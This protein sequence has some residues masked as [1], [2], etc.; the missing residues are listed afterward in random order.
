[1]KDVDVSVNNAA[2]NLAEYL[3]I[4]LPDG[5]TDTVRFW[6]K[7]EMVTLHKVD[8]SARSVFVEAWLPGG[9]IIKDFDGGTSGPGKARISFIPYAQINRIEGVWQD[10]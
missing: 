6:G 7:N 10:E 3:Q 9:I 1:M 8:Y 5:L 2:Y 4:L